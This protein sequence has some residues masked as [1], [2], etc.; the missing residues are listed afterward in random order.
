MAAYLVALASGDVSKL[1]EPT[2]V[3]VML[4]LVDKY[5]HPVV[6]AGLKRNTGAPSL[7]VV[8]LTGATGSL[9]AYLLAELLA[10]PEV[11]KVYCLARGR[12]D[13]Q[14]TQRVLESMVTR[15]LKLDKADSRVVSLA[16][17]L[18]E[19]NL[20]LDKAVYD[21]IASK[22]TM[23]IHVSRF[24]SSLICLPLSQQRD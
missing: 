18:G 10:N 17:D 6:P 24:S 14:A 2:N 7:A 22:V 23:V 13:E 21:E 3:E 11:K 20:G 9:G 15:G 16:S 12:S 8:V 1:K 4:Q 19:D 5:S